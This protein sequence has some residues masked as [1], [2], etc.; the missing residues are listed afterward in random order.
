MDTL[1]KLFSET[2]PTTLTFDC[3]GTLVDWEHG[4]A[5]ALRKIYGFST[6]QVSDDD[7]IDMFLEF[8]AVEIRKHVFPYR[9][10]LR[11]VAD[12]IAERLLGRTDPDHSKAFAL[13][14]PK[15]PV[16]PETDAALARMARHFRLAIISNVD[17]DLIS[18]TLRGIA[19]DFD[20]VVTSEQSGC[21]KPD[22]GIFNR[23]VQHLGEEP[24]RI[25]HI[26]EGLCEARPARQSGMKSIWVKRS[27]RSDDGSKAEPT[28]RASSLMEIVEAVEGCMTA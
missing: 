26:A 25:I 3:Y 17:D 6:R 27:S 4:A 9:D 19:V 11:N 20:L 13:S 16:F 7:L 14:L 24:A 5:V 23:T 18:E 8:D 2:R 10:V 21:Y 28:A 15:W 22:I 12:Q 1:K